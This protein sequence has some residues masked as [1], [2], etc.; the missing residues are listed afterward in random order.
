MKA[1]LIKCRTN[2]SINVR[3]RGTG[4]YR[5]FT[6]VIGVFEF[7]Q[8][9]YLSARYTSVLRKIFLKGCNECTFHTNL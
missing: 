2:F 1:D 5:S 4:V 6:R 3:R 7:K 9:Y 8:T